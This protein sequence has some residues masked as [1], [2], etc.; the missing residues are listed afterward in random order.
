M[1]EQIRPYGVEFDQIYRAAAAHETASRLERD[2]LCLADIAIRFASIERI[3]RYSPERRENDVE[4]SF[5]LGLV[6]QEIAA[7]YFPELNP[8]LVAQFASVHDLVELE[9]G[10]TPTFLITNSELKTKQSAEST[11]L[12]MLCHRLPQ[13]TAQLL[14]IYEEQD[15]PEARFVRFIDKLMPVLVDILGAG[16]QV[17][18]EDYAT[19]DHVQL[20]SAHDTLRK[21]F[22]QLFPEPALAPVHMA[23]NSLARKFRDHCVPLPQLQEVLF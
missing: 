22:E 12:E 17:M 1:S 2:A 15:V 20:E 16:S 4:H 14:R 13:H 19:Y 11:A 5:M 10:D 18:H 3:P 8:G 7:T 9:I 21:R 23:R 6:A